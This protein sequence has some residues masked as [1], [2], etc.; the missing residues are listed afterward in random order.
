MDILVLGGTGVI[1]TSIVDRLHDLSHHVTV[2]NRGRSRA[3]YRLTPEI[4]NADK[5]NREQ[6][7][8]ALKGR[9]FDAVIDM[10]SF[11]SADAELTLDV[12]GNRGGHFVFTSTVAAFRRPIRTIPAAEDNELC[13]N[14][15]AFPYG[16]YKARMETFIKTRMDEFPITVIRPSLTYGIGC[17]NVGVMRNNYGIVR[18]LRRRKP[19]VVFGDGVNPWAWTFAP[20]LA[21]AFAGVLLRP[22]CYGQFYNATSD[23]HHIWDDLYTEFARRVGVEPI[24]VHISTEMLLQAS[25]DPFLNLFQEKMYAGIFDNS[26]IRSVVPEFVCDYSLDKI[27]RALYDWYESDPEARNVDEARDKLED[28]IIERYYRCIDIMA[29]S[30]P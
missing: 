4:I 22:V 18:R 10:I 15:E 5:Q 2:L 12:L 9:S 29:G 28:S 30:N 25:S 8:A 13:T 17:R 26:K 7:A 6:F 14:E 16:Y 20:D 23:D 1:S 24:L 27:V 21:K 3:R 19:M 11:N